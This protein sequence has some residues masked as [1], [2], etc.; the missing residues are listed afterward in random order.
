MFATVALWGSCGDS[1]LSM[2]QKLQNRAARIVINSSYNAPAANLIKEL[3]WPT[4]HDMIKR[5]TATF[6]FK[7]KSGL[8][9]TYLST[10][11]RETRS[12]IFLRKHFIR[13]KN[14]GSMLMKRHELISINKS[15]KFHTRFLGSFVIS[16]DSMLTLYLP[17]C[18]NYLNNQ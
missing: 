13:F 11:L 8:A 17:E 6:V 16:S 2:L 3:K 18:K 7:S 12:K 14:D 5:E 10:L 9:P 4:V 15:V 1:R